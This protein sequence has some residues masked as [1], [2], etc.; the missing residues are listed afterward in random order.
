MIGRERWVKVCEQADQ[1]LKI[2]WGR[3]PDRDRR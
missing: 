2:A 1:G 3:C